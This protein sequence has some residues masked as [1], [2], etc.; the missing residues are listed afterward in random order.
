MKLIPVIAALA[1]A[2]TRPAVRVNGWRQDLAELALEIGSHHPA[3][4]TKVKEADWRAQIEDL[5]EQMPKL[6]DMQ[7]EVGLLRIVAK[8]GD[9]HT[10][11]Y[12]PRLVQYPVRFIVFDDG[13]FVVGAAP[14][15]EW[16]IGHK[17]VKVGNTGIDDALATIA[18]LVPYEN[19]ADRLNQ[20]QPLLSDPIA[21]KG[22]DLTLDDQAHFTLDNGRELS[23]AAGAGVSIAPPK[24]L[25]LHLQG[26]TELAY[27]NTYVADQRLLYF[28]YNA[29]GDDPHEKPFAEF[30]ADTLAFADQHPVDRFVIDLRNNQGGNS[31]VIEPLVD[32]LVARPALAGR[33]F[34]LIGRTTFSSAM[35][36]AIELKERLGAVLVGGPTGGN[37]NGFGEVK[38]FELPHSHLHAQYSTKRFSNDRYRGTSVT[39]DIAVRVTGDDWF[40]GRDPAMD[41]V[42]AAPVPHT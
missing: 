35:L 19:D 21:I 32:G 4:F 25:P 18:A 33:V 11:L 14:P 16:S 6:D 7:I 20:V 27:W 26:H 1:V 3:P 34:V 36:N 2:C 41:A 10:R 30:A 12:L 17:V 31:R 28:Q 15:N 8:I 5:D 13:V 42:L 22:T 29:C 24:T 39:P 40:S 9:A 37:P 38:E 23:V